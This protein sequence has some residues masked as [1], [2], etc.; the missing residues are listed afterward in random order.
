M[1]PVDDLR[2]QKEAFVSNLHGTTKQEIWLIIS[3]LPVCIYMGELSTSAARSQPA[4][5]WLPMNAPAACANLGDNSSHKTLLPVMQV[6]WRNS[7]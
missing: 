5:A 4:A 6:R 3:C 2:A 7:T 1:S